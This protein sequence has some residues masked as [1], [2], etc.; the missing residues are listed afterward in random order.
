MKCALCCVQ[1]K[2]CFM[3]C[4]GSAF[5]AVSVDSSGRVLS[6]GHEDGSCLL[7]DIRGNRTLQSFSSHTDE[8]RTIRFSPNA[9]YLLS[10]S[11]DQKVILSDLRGKIKSYLRY[12]I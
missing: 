1:N 4:A 2:M 5:A 12:T 11:Y 8:V 10:G 7:W 9:Y 3:L 6:S